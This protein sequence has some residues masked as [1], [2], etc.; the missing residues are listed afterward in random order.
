MMAAFV[1]VQLAPGVEPPPRPPGEPP[2]WMAS[3][4]A[5]LRT[6]IGAFASSTL[7]L[8]ALRAFEPPVYFAVGGRSNP[9]YYAQMAERARAI[10]ADITVEVFDERHHF[11]PPHRTEPEHTARA[12]RALWARP[13]GRLRLE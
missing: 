12:L 5:G 1:A 7:P 9:D 4:P 8:A 6:I 11:D 3:R 2:A 10:F 13:R